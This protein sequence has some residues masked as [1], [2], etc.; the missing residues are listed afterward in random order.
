MED[1]MAVVLVLLG[2]ILGFASGAAALV[3]TDLGL[4]AAMGIWVS[5]GLTATLLSLA[6]AVLPRHS[7]VAAGK[8]AHA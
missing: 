8:D 7:T 3:F 4:L 2:G 6:V 1:V 5:V